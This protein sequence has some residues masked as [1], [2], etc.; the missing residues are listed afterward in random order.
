MLRTIGIRELKNKLSACLRDVRH[1]DVYLVADRGLVV[2]ELKQPT[3]AR[4]AMG[5]IHPALSRLVAE[6]KMRAPLTEK[7]KGHRKALSLLPKK[8]GLRGEQIQAALEWTR[9]D[10]ATRIHR[11]RPR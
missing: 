8:T 7:G 3:V 1:G 2:A 6:G 11:K 4:P 10:R 5:A 9:G